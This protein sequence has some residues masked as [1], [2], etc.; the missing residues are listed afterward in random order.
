LQEGFD[1]VPVNPNHQSILGLTCY[2]S[3]IDVPRECRVDLVNVFRRPRFVEDIVRDVIRRRETTG[4]GP[5]IWTQIGVS[6]QSGEA[7][8]RAHRI[9][10]VANRCLM[11]EHGRGR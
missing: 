10:Y 8:A 11:V 6:S 7:L 1:V 4:Q 9:P 5:V 2:P 3:L